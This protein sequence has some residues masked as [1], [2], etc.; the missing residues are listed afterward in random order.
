MR[1]YDI[2]IVTRMNNALKELNESRE[3]SGTSI[4]RVTSDMP[5]SPPTMPF[6]VVTEIDNYATLSAYTLSA[7]E[8][9]STIVYDV[10]VY[11]GGTG[12]RKQVAKN[13][14]AILDD[15][16]RVLGFIRTSLTPL[17]GRNL[18]HIVG[19]YKANLN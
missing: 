3:R 2:E 18:F 7:T 6:V 8:P 13:I 11:N 15:V 9:L 5:E 12:Q 10:S 4:V 17:T 19:R 14:M 1:D 16:M